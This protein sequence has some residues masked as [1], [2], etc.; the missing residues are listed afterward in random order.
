MPA[1]GPVR[2]LERLQDL[3][4]SLTAGPLGYQTDN[5]DCGSDR[6]QLVTGAGG[7]QTAT[8]QT[9]TMVGNL[10]L[11]KDQPDLVDLTVRNGMFLHKTDIV[12][13]I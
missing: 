5:P 11:L 10:G 12:F 2:H 1:R 4:S 6:K 7:E 9:V 8:N 13:L 3:F